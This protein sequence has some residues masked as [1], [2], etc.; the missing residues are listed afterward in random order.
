MHLYIQRISV[1]VKLIEWRWKSIIWRN[2]QSFQILENH[3]YDNLKS[4]LKKNFGIFSHVLKEDSVLADDRFLI[5]ESFY[6]DK[7]IPLFTKI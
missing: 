1:I 2:F 4:R 6:F 3:Y 5:E 7:F